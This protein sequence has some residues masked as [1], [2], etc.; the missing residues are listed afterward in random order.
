MGMLNDTTI[1]TDETKIIKEIDSWVDNLE[2]FKN[3]KPYLKLKMTMQQL[4]VRN[5]VMYTRNLINELKDIKKV[6][7]I[8]KDILIY[9]NELISKVG[10]SNLLFVGDV[11]AA[12]VQH[13][14]D[15]YKTV[16]TKADKKYINKQLTVKLQPNL[17]I[18]VDI[19]NDN[20][21]ESQN[22][23]SWFYQIKYKTK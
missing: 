21:K 15:S 12:L 5:K 19:P 22:T 1:Y 3:N 10:S 14:V 9:R 16:F 11:D 7:K 13:I 20:N 2:N 6:F 17:N 8:K 23:I 4:L 18:T